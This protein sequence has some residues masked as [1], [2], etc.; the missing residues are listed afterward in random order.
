LP[1]KMRERSTPSAVLIRCHPR[2]IHLAVSRKAVSLRQTWRRLGNG[3]FGGISFTKTATLRMRLR[4]SCGSESREPST[5]LTKCSLHPSPSEINKGTLTPSSR[6]RACRHRHRLRHHLPCRRL[7]RP[8][9]PRLALVERGH[10]QLPSDHKG[11]GRG[12]LDIFC[13][14][15]MVRLAPLWQRSNNGRLT[16]AWRRRCQRYNAQ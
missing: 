15:S 13:S 3:W 5:T 9:L 8:L 4:N 7:R 1:R 14:C 2:E 10:R 6:H 16:D 11:L 12:I